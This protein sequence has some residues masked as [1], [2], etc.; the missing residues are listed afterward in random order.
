MQIV[1]ATELW[2]RVAALDDLH[3]R[4]AAEPVTVAVVHGRHTWAPRPGP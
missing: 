4:R 2:F 3:A 1:E